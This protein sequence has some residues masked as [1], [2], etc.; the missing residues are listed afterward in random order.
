MRN[1]P[2]TFTHSTP[3]GKPGPATRAMPSVTPKRITA[4]IAPPAA[5][6]KRVI[7]MARCLAPAHGV[8]KRGG[9]PA[10]RPLATRLRFLQMTPS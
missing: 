8:V 6:C 1:E 7:I 5:T 2:T 3:S 4:P 10:R 9:L